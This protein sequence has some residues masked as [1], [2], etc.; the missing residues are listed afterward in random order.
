MET[1][2]YCPMKPIV[3]RATGRGIGP[4]RECDTPEA[5][6]IRAMCM[7]AGPTGAMPEVK[8]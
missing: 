2:V 1:L 8:S 5:C 3:D 4:H 6:K 7:V